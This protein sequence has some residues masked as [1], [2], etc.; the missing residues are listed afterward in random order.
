MFTFNLSVYADSIE[1]V[2]G[3]SEVVA[4]EEKILYE[5][6]DM[7]EKLRLLTETALK[8]EIPPEILKAIAL[9]ES[10]MMQ[11]KDGKP[12]ISDDNGIGI[13]QVTNTTLDVDQEKLAID[14][15]YNIEIGAKILKNKWGLQFEGRIPSIN[16]ANPTIIENWYFAIMAY[17]GLSARNDPNKYENTYQERIYQT[18]ENY[19]QIDVA[20]FPNIDI[21]YHSNGTM[22]FPNKH[23]E[24]ESAVTE[25]TQMF[26]PGNSVYVM[27]SLDP[28]KYDY[29]NLRAVPDQSAPV[30]EEIAYYTELEI[31]GGPYIA[32]S[33]RYNQFVMYEVKG[34]DFSGFIASSNIRKKST[35]VE[36][37][38]WAD[39]KGSSDV[40][41]KWTINLSQPVN[42]E[43]VHARNIYIVDEAGVGVFTNINFSEDGKTIFI[44]PETPFE[45]G[46][47]YS[48]FI[49]DLVSA[50]HELL[51]ESIRLPFSITP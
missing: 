15:A 7:K 22:F 37:E 25:S 5:E 6:L 12:L 40:K 30:T 20:E 18:V 14:T 49:K 31:V 23:L 9:K 46:K 44:E 4:S 35:N 29:G 34:V 3:E 11:F 51:R 45:P 48:L 32:S 27:N 21:D 33:N 47:D 41:K 28:Y 17:N 24:W 39:D 16:D 8:Y 19:S 13:M 42:P 10:D 1:H 38:V 50:S 43:T 2:Q 26:L 36:F